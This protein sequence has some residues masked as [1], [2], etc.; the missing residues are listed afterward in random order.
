MC[1]VYKESHIYGSTATLQFTVVVSTK[2]GVGKTSFSVQF[3]GIYAGMGQR[4]LLVDA[5]F[6]QSLSL[7]MQL[8]ELIPAP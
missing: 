4:V 7:F 6:Q 5:D 3:G 1:S 2:G 8:L